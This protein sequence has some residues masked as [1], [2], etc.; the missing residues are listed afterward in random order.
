LSKAQGL[1]RRFKPTFPG[2]RSRRL[3]KNLGVSSALNA[4]I[5]NAR[6]DYI[7]FLALFHHPL[8]HHPYR[9]SGCHF[10]ARM[11]TVSP[12]RRFARKSGSSARQ[13]NQNRGPN[14]RIWLRASSWPCPFRRS[15]TRERATSSNW[16]GIRRFSSIRLQRGRV[17]GPGRRRCAARPHRTLQILSGTRRPSSGGCLG[18]ASYPWLGVVI[19]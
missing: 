6:G 10:T 18:V 11:K 15:A 3:E 19:V 9:K 17:L 7:A 4:G 16:P 8:G 13:A 14:S 1:A 12:A 2:F 5:R